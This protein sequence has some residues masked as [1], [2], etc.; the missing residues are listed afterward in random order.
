MSQE[1]YDYIIVGAG[2]AGCILAETLS[3]NGRYRV[4]LL[5]AGG[6]DN[7]FWIKVPLGYAFLFANPAVNWRFKAEPDAGL[8]DRRAYWP[9]GKVIGGSGSINAMF[10]ARGL[11]HDF[12]DWEASGAKGWHWDAVR[13]TYD[14]LETRAFET[15]T[16]RTETQG[17]GP[18]QVAT[19]PDAIHPF[20]RTFLQAAGQIGW[21]TVPDLNA[22]GVEGLSTVPANLHRGRRWSSA[23]AFL[24][25]T[26]RRQNLRIVRHAHA[27]RVV[28]DGKRTTGVTYRVGGK[29]V[30]VHSTREVIL[31]AGAVNSPKL[32]QLSGI[33]PAEVLKHHGVPVLHHLPQ[34]GRGLQD[35]LG[36]SQM[37]QSNKDT[38]NAQLSPWA[39]QLKAGLEYVLRR[40]GPLSQP[41]NQCS[42]FVRSSPDQA[43]PDMQVYCN[44]A[45][46]AT[47]EDSAPS[48]DRVS[49]FSLCAQPCRPS[50]RGW[51]EI[52]SANPE[53]AAVIQPNSLST[54][55]DRAAAIRA[56]RVLQTLSQAPAIQAVT[57][58]AV[59][60]DITVMTD[61][62]LLETF[63]Q[64]AS[65]VFHP[66]CTCK[67]GQSQAHSVL[68]PRLRVH[69]MAG[70]RVIGAS[71]FPNITSGNTNAPTM[72][73]AQRGAE[74]VLEDAGAA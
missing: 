59:A 42:G 67:M 2:S 52:R 14:A 74:M 61:D 44:P 46:Y 38:L 5:E 63:R 47:P 19:R 20:T 48:I 71:A 60:P 24:G 28:F 73:L 7:R 11:A 41:I 4:I 64:R 39:G 72:M 37:F 53:D 6:S 16:G 1:T 68:D 13:A 40:S 66:T 56:G 26:R 54:E 58:A 70:L 49:G 31:S 62:D 34:V 10:Y 8:S 32:L 35:H 50:S 65:T 55:E 15:E 33:G 3:R 23:D 43:R 21:G 36:L 22:P 9:R 18:L 29:T 69:G 17:A 30:T 57:R 45:L 12:D 25:Q 51:I 27:E